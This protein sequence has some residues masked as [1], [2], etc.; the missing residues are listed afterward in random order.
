[1]ERVFHARGESPSKGGAGFSQRQENRGV[2]REP[3]GHSLGELGLTRMWEAKVS[4]RE[5]KRL[6]LK[7][8]IDL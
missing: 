4:F 2:T 6:K 1:M 3:R 8:E 5:Y 7:M